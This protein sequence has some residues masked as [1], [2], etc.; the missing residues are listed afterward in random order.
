MM[1]IPGLFGIAGLLAGA[2]C[3]HQT[4]APRPITVKVMVLPDYSLNVMAARV[5]PLIAHLQ[6]SFGPRYRVEWISC[7]S[8]EAFMATVERERPDVSLQDAFQTAWLIRL[9]QAEP[10]LGVLMPGGE[11]RTRGLVIT[12]ADG[13]VRTLA[14]L[15]GRRVAIASRRSYLGY[16]AQASM[17]E[18]TANVH[19]GSIHFVPVRWSDR[20]GTCMEQG[21]AE[22]GFVSE[23]DLFPG[24]RVLART[25]PIPA[26]CVVTFP[27]TPGEVADGVR[28]ALQGLGTGGV[29]NIS[30]LQG[31]GIRG[32]TPIDAQE[33]AAIVRL[34][35]NA[36]VPY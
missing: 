5:A 14:D 9:Q 24:A 26:S 3:G 31:L 10:I 7:P 36:S 25:E 29:E 27:H 6:K 4:S 32:F 23:A 30:V 17:L 1:A 2:G 20:V 22:A 28:R 8:P 19:A 34:A 18:A 35:E 15:A 11:E 33:H 13:D 21:R 16:I 12:A